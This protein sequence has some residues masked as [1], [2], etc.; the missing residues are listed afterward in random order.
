MVDKSDRR[1]CGACD[2]WSQTGESQVC[3]SGGLMCT[4]RLVQGMADLTDYCIVSAV[5][6]IRSQAFTGCQ[7]ALWC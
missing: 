5:T 3:D 7:E 1:L 4:G 2:S 6:L